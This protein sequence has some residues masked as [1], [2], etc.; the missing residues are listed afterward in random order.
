M[1][2]W[3]LLVILVAFLVGEWIVMSVVKDNEEANMTVT[4]TL[5]IIIGVA[6]FAGVSWW[7]ITRFGIGVVL[8]IIAALGVGGGV[9]YVLAKKN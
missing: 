7:T 3:L 4:I 9:S 5:L 2:V 8:L 6:L 1:N